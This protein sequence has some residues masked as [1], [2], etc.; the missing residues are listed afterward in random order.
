MVQKFLSRLFPQ[1]TERPM[2]DLFAELAELQVQAADTHSKLL[3]HTYR[4]RTRIAPKLHEQ[5]T[6]AE[7]LCRRIAQRLVQS[8]ITPYEAELLYDF[9]LTLADAVDAMEHTAELLVVS[10]IGTLPTPLLDAAKGIERASE[11][12]VAATWK[13]SDTQDL[14][15]YYAQVRKLKRQGDRLVR[16]ALGELYKKGGAAQEMLPLHDVSES[17]RETI[18]LQERSARITDLLRVKDA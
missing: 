8:L 14:G 18:T 1:R 13:L 6:V 17:V 15:D 2:Y 4:E 11:L 3:G 10:R 12:T 5:S 7:E 9:A 16:Q